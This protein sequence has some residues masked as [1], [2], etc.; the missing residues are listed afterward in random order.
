[1]EGSDGRGNV[2]VSDGRDSVEVSDGCGSLE[3]EITFSNS[4]P[5]NDVIYCDNQIH[6]PESVVRSL[7]SSYR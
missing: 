2:E 5:K 7:P 6:C 3:E 4:L 1:M